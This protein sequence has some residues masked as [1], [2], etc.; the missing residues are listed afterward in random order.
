MPWRRHYG[1]CHVNVILSQWERIEVR[2]TTS[3]QSGVEGPRQTDLSRG[4][5]M[6]MTGVSTAVF[7]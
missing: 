5:G 1:R 2:G 7:H 3:P 4:E 6:K